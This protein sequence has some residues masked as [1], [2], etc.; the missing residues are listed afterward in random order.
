MQY[1][2]IKLLLLLFMLSS[3]V[4]SM[5]DEPSKNAK[6]IHLDVTGEENPEPRKIPTLFELALDKTYESLKDLDESEREELILSLPLSFQESCFPKD[7]KKAYDRYSCLNKETRKKFLDLFPANDQEKILGSYDMVDYYKISLKEHEKSVKT[8]KFVSPNEFVSCSKDGIVNLWNIKIDAVK[9]FYA[10]SH[11]YICPFLY[12][13]VDLSTCGR[14][15]VVNSSHSIKIWDLN[16]ECE[17]HS[18]IK[19][20]ALRINKSPGCSHNSISLGFGRLYFDSNTFTKSIIDSIKVHPSGNYIAI[21]VATYREKR[22]SRFEEY[23][24]ESKESEIIVL[25]FQKIIKDFIDSGSKTYTHF[26][27]ESYIKYRLKENCEFTSFCF[28]SAGLLMACGFE[29]GTIR[30]Y[31]VAKELPITICISDFKAHSKQIRHI[32]FSKDSKY[33]VSVAPKEVK[34]WQDEKCIEFLLTEPSKKDIEAKEEDDDYR[35]GYCSVYFSS[36]NKYLVISES[37]GLVSIWDWNNNNFVWFDSAEKDDW[38][39]FLQ[40]CEEISYTPCAI[41]S[42]DDRYLFVS[43]KKGDIKVFDLWE[44]LE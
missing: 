27:I 42:P 5:E 24:L 35:D 31:D 20:E 3:N 12:D 28:D 13:C 6:K 2:I 38:S 11:G 25:D 30:I 19:E 8:M 22:H 7:N 43:W 15:L 10:S 36:N 18:E 4:F 17:C 33:L 34:I 37:G 29:D 23:K 14:Y 40:P 39:V 16:S 21:K 41:F 32:E 9:T 26:H 44:Y 1:K